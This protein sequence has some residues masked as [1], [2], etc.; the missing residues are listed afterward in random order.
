MSTLT[1]K[2]KDNLLGEYQL[3]DSFS[4]T[5]GRAGKN[6]VV[7]QD[8]AVSGHHAKIDPVGDRFVLIDL[9][10]KNGTFVNENLVIS[11]WLKHGDVISIGNHQLIFNQYSTQQIF[12][13]DMEE[14]D[15]TII[16]DTSRHRDMMIK[17]NPT[18]SIHVVRFWDKGHEKNGGTDEQPMAA[19]PYAA[20]EDDQPAGVITYLAGGFGKVKLKRK[21]STIGKHPSSDVVVKG[22]LVGQTA[23]TI[24]QKP[25]GFYLTHISGLAKPKVDGN[26]VKV[27]TIIDDLS[28][29]EIGS[30][31]LQFSLEDPKS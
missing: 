12:D 22:F 2:L 13:D 29:I 3:Q 17:S 15:K 31:K 10:S 16:M 24:T 6:D 25:E 21:I 19:S 27:P 4:L 14:L 20:V 28:I 9:Q 26:T 7:I 23:F 18:K 30:A 1:L 11:H 5:I 8:P